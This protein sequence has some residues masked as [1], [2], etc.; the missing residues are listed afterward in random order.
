MKLNSR[1]FC[2]QCTKHDKNKLSTRHVILNVDVVNVRNV[3]I[4]CR[5][6]QQMLNVREAN[7]I[8]RVF[9]C[10]HYLH[11]SGD[12]T[13]HVRAV[14]VME[15]TSF[16]KW[17]IFNYILQ[18]NP[19]LHPKRKVCLC[20]CWQAC[21]YGWGWCSL[22]WNLHAWPDVWVSTEG[23]GGGEREGVSTWEN[24]ALEENMCCGIVTILKGVSR[25]QPEPIA[26]SEQLIMGFSHSPGSRNLVKES[27]MRRD[28]FVVVKH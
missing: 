16:W 17:T 11:H 22:S 18:T 28:C 27:S 7:C 1:A 8:S 23:L 10:L 9:N 12:I 25:P 3:K 24:C 13:L 19:N 15:Y 21:R 26:H 6:Q 4:K 5:I 2:S 14:F 20:V